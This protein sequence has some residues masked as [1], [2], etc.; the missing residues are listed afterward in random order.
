MP[1]SKGLGVCTLLIVLTLGIFSFSVSGALSVAFRAKPYYPH[2]I[3][4]H[5]VTQTRRDTH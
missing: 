2:G 5:E 4:A 1:D 3:I